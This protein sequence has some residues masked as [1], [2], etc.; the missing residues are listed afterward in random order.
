MRQP[1]LFVKIAAVTSSVLLVAACVGYR[2]GAFNWLSTDKPTAMGGS[3]SKPLVD[4]VP[5][6]TKPAET[7]PATDLSLM[8]GSKSAILIVPPSSGSSGRQ[9]PP[10]Q[11]SSPT[12]MYSSKSIA[13][14]INL[15]GT[16]SSQPIATPPAPAPETKP[17]SPTIMGGSKSSFRPVIQIELEQPLLQGFDRATRQPPPPS[18]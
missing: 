7:A 15:P 10:T 1:N 13:P 17:R 3:K 5:P 8:S 14:V 6:D 4:P 11:Q 12:I 2:A 9:S 16:Q 18:K